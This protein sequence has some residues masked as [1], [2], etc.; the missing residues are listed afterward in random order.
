[1]IMPNN[2]DVDEIAVNA[3]KL[4]EGLRESLDTGD[5][6]GVLDDLNLIRKQIMD[7]IIQRGRISWDKIKQQTEY[8]CM[9]GDDNDR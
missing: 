2:F 5:L 6:L 7:E 1:M 8:E 3:L 4:V 9:K